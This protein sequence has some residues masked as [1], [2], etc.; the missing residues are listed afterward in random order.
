MIS[1]KLKKVGNVCNRHYLAAHGQGTPT[2]H[3]DQ[4]IFIEERVRPPQSYPHNYHRRRG[5]GTFLG[6]ADGYE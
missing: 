3:D 5:R 1:E 4:Q 2:A 6:H